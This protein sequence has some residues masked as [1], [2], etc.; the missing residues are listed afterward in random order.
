[1]G[2]VARSKLNHKELI[3]GVRLTMSQ[4]GHKC[5]WVNVAT[6]SDSG[7]SWDEEGGG[8]HLRLQRR[9]VDIGRFP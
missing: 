6:R 8:S 1:M 2:L 9:N 3:N 7:G 5:L 4:A